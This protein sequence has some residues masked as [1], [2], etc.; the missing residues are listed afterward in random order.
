MHKFGFF[1]LL[2]HRKTENLGQ[3]R[4]SSQTASVMNK[5]QEKL[6]EEKLSTS[7]II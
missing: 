3:W 1:E 2:A 7:K 5:A 6:S 4:S